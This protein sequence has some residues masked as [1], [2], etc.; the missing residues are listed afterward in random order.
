M[1][2]NQRYIVE[3]L[4]SNELYKYKNDLIYAHDKYCVVEQLGKN[5][6]LGYPVWLPL[7]FIKLN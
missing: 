7:N 6:W 1:C 5:K 2:C 3:Q 4:G